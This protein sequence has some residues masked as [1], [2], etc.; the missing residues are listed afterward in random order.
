MSRYMIKKC[1]PFLFFLTLKRFPR[2]H[3]LFCP[4]RK[5]HPSLEIKIH[6]YIASTHY[7]LRCSISVGT[8]ASPGQN[9]SNFS[10]NSCSGI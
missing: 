7:I 1:H 2:K 4:V 6:L 10:L 8:L 5:N 3:A 9:Q